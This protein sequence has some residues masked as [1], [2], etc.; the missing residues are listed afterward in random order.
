[1]VE[2][3]LAILSPGGAKNVMHACPANSIRLRSRGFAARPFA[4]QS[5]VFGFRLAEQLGTIGGTNDKR[6][7]PAGLRIWS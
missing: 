7:P 6:P 2:R 4:D 5:N 3:W 1:V